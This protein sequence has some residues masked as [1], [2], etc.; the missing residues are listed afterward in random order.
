MTSTYEQLRMEKLKRNS[1]MMSEL[2]LDNPIVLT[3]AKPAIRRA[4]ASATAADSTPPVQ[5]RRRSTR[6]AKTEGEEELVE[7]GHQNT[8]RAQQKPEKEEETYSK[9]EEE[10]AQALGSDME[11]GGDSLLKKIYSL[12]FHPTKPNLLA[13]GGHGGRVALFNNSAVTL[14]FQVTNA[15]VSSVKLVEGNL[16][17]VSAN[18][19]KIAGYDHTLVSSAS[20]TTPKALFSTGEA[21]AGKGIFDLAVTG[22]QVG[23]CSK[24]GSLTLSSLDAAGSGLSVVRRVPQAH[25]GV[26]KSVG[27]HPN[28]PNLLVSGGNDSAIRLWDFR[29]PQ[30]D[31]QLAW[32]SKFG[33]A[34]NHVQFAT[35][36]DL[37]LVGSFA[38][39]M[40]LFDSRFP[41]A[42]AREFTGHCPP[43][44]RKLVN[45]YQPVLVGQN[46]VMASAGGASRLTVFD[47]DTAL[48]L[49]QGEVGWEAHATTLHAPSS[50]VAVS[51]G[52]RV[53][54]FHL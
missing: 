29:S 53:S 30:H 14:S 8:S 34:V 46:R 23:T 33:L 54:L 6:I 1:R 52:A 24:D 45:I 25:R 5:P 27:F 36:P 47:L 16:L 3:P 43:E 26:C 50:L 17:L 7:M 49:S 44:Q 31:P 4:K 38:T 18:D 20:P 19:G 32:E 13:A 9:L 41:T 10:E 21:H 12:D 40:E 22:N 35:S 42:P 15:W 28:N 39:T 11:I 48:V 37:V 51:H 2:G